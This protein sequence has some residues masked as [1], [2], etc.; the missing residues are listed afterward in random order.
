MGGRQSSE[1]Q[2]LIT[3]TKG[4]V[5]WTESFRLFKSNEVITDDQGDVWYRETAQGYRRKTDQYFW[6]FDP[7]NSNNIANMLPPSIIELDEERKQKFSNSY[8]TL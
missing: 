4:N 2:T 8:R 7:R 5:P 1:K 3:D 6:P